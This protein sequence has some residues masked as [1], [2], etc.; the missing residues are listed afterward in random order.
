[1]LLRSDDEPHWLRAA[2]EPI[3]HLFPRLLAQGEYSA[4]LRQPAP[5]T[6]A[7]LRWLADATRPV[8]CLRRHRA[9]P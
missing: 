9:A 2:P 5:L 6:E 1:V 8:R 4:R 7:A 3:G